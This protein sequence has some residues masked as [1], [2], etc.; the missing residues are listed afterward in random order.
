MGSEVQ[1]SKVQGSVQPPAKKTA[2]LSKKK[3]MNIEHRT[4]N[5]CILSV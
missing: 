3:L 1:G 5:K 2:N 4:S